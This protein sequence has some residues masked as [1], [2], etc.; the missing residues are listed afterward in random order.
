MLKCP[1]VFALLTLIAIRARRTNQLNIHGLSVGEALIGDYKACGLTRQEY[2]TTKNK[3]ERIG[4]ATFRTTNKGTIATILDTSIYDINIEQ[5]QPSTKPAINYPAT[6]NNPKANQQPTT[7]NNLNNEKNDEEP[8]TTPPV[9]GVGFSE[10]FKKTIA[11]LTMTDGGQKLLANCNNNIEDAYAWILWSK[12]QKQA[13][14]PAGLI[15][16]ESAKT[17]RPSL[18][19]GL[20]IELEKLLEKEFKYWAKEVYTELIK[21]NPNVA[22]FI[23]QKITESELGYDRPKNKNETL[24]VINAIE[25]KKYDLNAGEKIGG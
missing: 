13:K 1:K 21:H 8:T 17:S 20:Q 14:N 12:K 11:P 18:P 6:D 10:V 3:L 5:E 23:C 15:L 4:L 19:R 7:N 2:R 16:S 24:I 25:N 22:D 9:D